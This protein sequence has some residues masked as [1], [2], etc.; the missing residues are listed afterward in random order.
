ME[1]LTHVANDSWYK[2]GGHRRSVTP[3]QDAGYR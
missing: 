3:V 2:A 1:K